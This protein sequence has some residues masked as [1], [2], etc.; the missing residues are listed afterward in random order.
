M[1]LVL[2]A[3]APRRPIAGA[4]EMGEDET[5]ARQQAPAPTRR[6]GPHHLNSRPSYQGW[7]AYTTTLCKYKHHDQPKMDN[8]SC[9]GQARISG[10]TKSRYL[11]EYN[12]DESAPLNPQVT[13]ITGK[14]TTIPMD[15]TGTFQ[16]P[17]SNYK[18][19]NPTKIQL[20][21]KVKDLKFEN[22]I[23]K[24]HVSELEEEV[25]ELK[26]IATS[27][28]STEKKTMRVQLHGGTVKELLD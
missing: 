11:T 25:S 7:A 9:S 14:F 20:Q 19:M 8:T 27:T 6:R 18:I 17:T 23:L 12:T 1:R 13:T 21:Q 5:L 4:R 24:G 3:F 22:G 26:E 15:M 10:A 2:R 16:K 28:E